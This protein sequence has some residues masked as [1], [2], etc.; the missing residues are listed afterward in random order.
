MDKRHIMKEVFK[1]TNFSS[2]HRLKKVSLILLFLIVLSSTTY[3]YTLNTFTDGTSTGNMTFTGAGSKYFNL[4]LP[5]WAVI[6]KAEVDLERFNTNM[7]YL[8]DVGSIHSFNG[9]VRANASSSRVIL[10]YD[11]GVMELFNESSFSDHVCLGDVGA[12]GVDIYKGG[13]LTD[14]NNLWVANDTS[15]ASL[16]FRDISKCTG[17]LTCQDDSPTCADGA[18]TC[19]QYLCTPQFSIP[20]GD[21]S[22]SED[23]VY[24]ITAKDDSFV[25]ISTFLN[26]SI[27]KYNTAGA[28]QSRISFDFNIG[29]IHL[30]GDYFWACI[31]NTNKIAKI[32]L[33]GINIKNYTM[34][35]GETC[36]SGLHMQDFEN[37]QKIL[38]Q[39]PY[40]L[41]YAEAYTFYD[42]PSNVTIKTDNQLIYSEQYELSD[43]NT[44]DLNSSVL[45]SCVNSVSSGN[46]NCTI[47]FTSATVGILNYS[48]LDIEYGDF[49][50]DNCSNGSIVV[51]N[52]SGRSEETDEEMNLSL[53]IYVYPSSG[54]ETSMN[55]TN[56]LSG[57]TY[58]TFCSKVNNTD[59]RVDSIMEYGDGTEYT[60]RKYYLNNFTIDTSIVNDVYLYHLNNSKASEIT[61]T[62]FDSTTGD[63][64]S[65][66]YIHILRYYPGENVFR[67]VE[68]AKTDEVGESLGKMVLADVFY[69]F[70][71]KKPAGTIRLDT[72]IL[73]VLSLTRSFGISFA[74]DYLDTWTRINDVD[75]S[76]TCTRETKTCRITWSDSSSVVQD[77]RLEVWRI[78]GL[79]DQMIYSSTTSAASG[80]ISYTI[81][82]DTAGNKYIAKGF[83]ESNTG[84]S[85]YPTNWASLIYS[86][87][88]F[89]TDSTNRLASL[90]PLFMLAVVI[91]FALVDFGVLGVVIGSMLGLITGSIIGIIPLSPFYFISFIIMG[92]ILLYK[93]S[94]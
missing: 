30:D 56:E 3:A 91:V 92:A 68:I 42:T 47:N 13:G 38:Y 16:K 93:L 67:T 19:F 76:V 18:A 64:V 2:F 9:I 39:I 7:P 46:A 69:K 17:S 57:S 58:Y 72:G 55:L 11:D 4:S 10:L 37:G 49:Y 82:E 87:N 73:R 14:G 40:G 85:T 31:T 8:D 53:N 25:Y 28:L 22:G 48:N 74:E 35:G 23:V 6:T 43:I 21:I 5:Y 61:F 77:V 59:L 75:T 70:L 88:P 94:K 81:T 52:I 15:G 44:I 79:A 51:L 26:K 80:T 50:L 45:Q 90:F 20:D 34:S 12:A 66:A 54:Y 65:D 41:T 84:Q 83:V 36:G 71:I 60:Y 27:I 33:D 32:T 1:D 62:V 29:G 86:D 89:F 78:N 24:G 63:K